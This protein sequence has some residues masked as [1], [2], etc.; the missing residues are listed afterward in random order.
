MR[1]STRPL[2]IK[3]P[4]D[5]ALLRDR[6]KNDL[7]QP[8]PWWSAVLFGA[9]IRVAAGDTRPN[10]APGEFADY[11]WLEQRYRVQTERVRKHTYIPFPEDD[12][13]SVEHHRRLDALLDA[14]LAFVGESPQYDSEIACLSASMIRD[15]LNYDPEFRLPIKGIA[16]LSG[17]VARL[18]VSRCIPLDES[19]KRALNTLGKS[20]SHWRSLFNDD[21]VCPTETPL[22][23][24]KP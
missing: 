24:I 17:L 2:G 12:P 11:P 10:P 16:V 18:S 4:E 7:P 3:G 9:L 14:S 13:R 20:L 21:V 5:L 15:A 6:F 23:G 1:S 19:T 22:L 8:S